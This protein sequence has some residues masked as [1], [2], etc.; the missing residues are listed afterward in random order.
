MKTAPDAGPGRFFS[1]F[2]AADRPCDVS[3]GGLRPPPT[4][5][6]D[7]FICGA[8]RL[9]APNHTPN[10]ESFCYVKRRERRFQRPFL[11]PCRKKKR[12]LESKEKGAPVRVKWLQIGI[13]RPVFTPPLS[14]STVH[15]RL[16]R[17]NR[18]SRGSIPHFFAACVG[19]GRAWWRCL[20]FPLL[21]RSAVCRA[22]AG[23]L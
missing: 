5:T 23:R 4:S 13:R 2:W 21:R 10:H 3:R 20:V 22:A 7:C 18:E 9:G 17:W 11:F 15:R 6:R 16:R 1:V 8:R 12:F 19:G 14:T